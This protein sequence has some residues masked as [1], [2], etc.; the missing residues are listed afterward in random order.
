[1]PDAFIR[2]AD[3]LLIAPTET[4][5]DDTGA[6]QIPEIVQTVVNAVLYNGETYNVAFKIGHKY[7]KNK[8]FLSV[9]VTSCRRG[10]PEKA[11]A[12]HLRTFAVDNE[13][14]R[15]TDIPEYLE[16]RLNSPTT[17]PIFQA[18]DGTWLFKWTLPDSTTLYPSEDYCFLFDMSTFD[19]RQSKRM[20]RGTDRQ[21]TYRDIR[22]IK[23]YKFSRRFHTYR[24]YHSLK[25]TPRF[26]VRPAPELFSEA[27]FSRM[28]GGRDLGRFLGGD[29]FAF[30]Y[31]SVLYNNEVGRWSQAVFLDSVDKRAE[32][33]ANWFA[34]IIDET[35]QRWRER[36][37]GGHRPT[38]YDT[39]FANLEDRRR[40][41]MRAVGL[42]YHPNGRDALK[43]VG[44][45]LL[46]VAEAYEDSLRPM[47][48]W[49][50]YIKNDLGMRLRNFALDYGAGFFSAR[51]DMAKWVKEL[52]KL[53]RGTHPTRDRLDAITASLGGA[54]K[55]KVRIPVTGEYVT[56]PTEIENNIMKTMTR[57]VQYEIR[58]VMWK[59]G[60][61]LLNRP[62][63]WDRWGNTLFGFTMYDTARAAV[64]SSVIRLY[65]TKFVTMADTYVLGRGHRNAVNKPSPSYIPPASE[66]LVRTP[67]IA[68]E[69]SSDEEVDV[70]IEIDH[71][72]NEGLLEP[73]SDDDSG[74]D[75]DAKAETL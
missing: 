57:L 42:L 60:N 67:S 8:P 61:Y 45:G 54:K 29:M 30:R 62:G 46:K 47:G 12:L 64:T 4:L 65:G 18:L 37:F 15:V 59:M 14:R 35:P 55:G 50:D 52:K 40:A 39:G 9:Y 70:D 43:Q 16:L 31:F 11:E 66:V 44:K 22:R 25:V 27:Y 19:P 68:S 63:K 20:Q 21:K 56:A 24:H 13:T 53:C 48:R 38:Y 1:M 10:S 74:I 7:P 51:Q 36:A 2:L 49:K 32:H 73:P 23:P 58:L 3:I 72:R 26:A 33:V 41:S 75:Q 6:E 28:F 69:S 71:L 17:T 5:A 34:E